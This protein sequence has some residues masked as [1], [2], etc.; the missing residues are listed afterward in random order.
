M[1]LFRSFLTNERGAAA[2]EM[3]MI[4]PAAIALLFTTFEGAWYI[5]NEHQ[6]VKG[7]RDASR[8]AARLDFS[9]YQ[10]PAATFSGPLAD[11]QNIARTGQIANGSTL[12]RGWTNDLVQVDV[13]C[14]PGMGG[15]YERTGGYAPVVRVRSEVPYQT[16]LGSLTLPSTFTIKAKAESPVM[17][18]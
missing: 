4:L 1:R 14:T 9:N 15:L 6:I 16:M 12:V 3:A 11:I 8:Y 7:V 18:L 17:G 10:C 2:A 5:V 13:I